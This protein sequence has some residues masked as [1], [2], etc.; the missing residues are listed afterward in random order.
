MPRA[1]ITCP[2]R[3]CLNYIEFPSHGIGSTV[4]CPHCQQET[5]LFNPRAM[6]KRAKR[7]FVWSLVGIA[8]TLLLL[9]VRSHVEERQRAANAE[10]AKLLKNLHWDAKLTSQEIERANYIYS[11]ASRTQ[12]KVD[13][14]ETIVPDWVDHSEAQAYITILKRRN[15]TPWAWLVL[16]YR[17]PQC[18]SELGIVVRRDEQKYDLSMA[19][20]KRMRHG[21]GAGWKVGESVSFPLSEKVEFVN[22][23]IESKLAILRYKGKED[24]VSVDHEIT[25]EERRS[26]KDMILLYRSL[27]G[28]L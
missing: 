21:K 22:A 2:C 3:H 6:T 4:Q 5:T 13:D 8:L 27:S 1:F 12:D 10:K 15:E 20:G 9:A 26:L 19:R 16:Y 14:D 25:S 24:G 11:K 28:E 18:I 23:L 7:T 17:T